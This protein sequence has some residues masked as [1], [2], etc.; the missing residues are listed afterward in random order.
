[1]QAIDDTYRKSVTVLTTRKVTGIRSLNHI[2]LN[3]IIGSMVQSDI[4]TSCSLGIK[5]QEVHWYNDWFE[6]K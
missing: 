5:R 3:T 2:R 6:L 4:G 1:M